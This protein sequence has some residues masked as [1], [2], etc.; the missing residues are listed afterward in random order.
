[1]N[2]LPVLNIGGGVRV[3]FIL[4]NLLKVLIMS[5]LNKLKTLKVA[6]AANRSTP[7]TE[8][9]ALKLTNQLIA[10]N[11]M[12]VYA[13]KFNI[14]KP[15]RVQVRKWDS[16]SRESVYEQH[17]YFTNIDVAAAVGTIVSAATFGEKGL[18]GQFDQEKA[19]VHPEFIAWLAD[20]RNQ[21]TLAL[22]AL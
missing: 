6:T 9:Q 4:Y 8:A 20:D 7:M 22:A 3:L 5:V 21:A 10:D 18:A 19:E 1:M 11:R 17:G 16:V 15:Y 12:N 2:Q 13:N 14:K